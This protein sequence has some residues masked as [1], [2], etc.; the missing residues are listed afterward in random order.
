MLE[1]IKYLKQNKYNG[2]DDIEKL[3]KDFL[4]I[5]IKISYDSKITNNTRRIIF[6][7]S[8]S[9]RTH[10]FGKITYECN[11]LILQAPDWKVLCASTPTPKTNVKNSV[12]SD[13]LQK[14]IY[15]LYEITDGTVINLYYWNS[16]WKIS[17]ARGIDMTDVEL[18]TADNK[19]YKELLTDILTNMKYKTYQAFTDI[20]DN[21]KS[22]TFIIKHPILHKFRPELLLKFVHSYDKKIYKY[23]Y[24][25]DQFIHIKQKEIQQIPLK[26]IYKNL[27]SAFD[28]YVNNK[29]VLYGYILISNYK[30][31]TNHSYIVLESNLL[32]FIRQSLY[33]Q[34]FIQYGNYK[35][36]AVDVYA[37]L[38]STPYKNN[39]LNLFPE[40]K[41]LFDKFKNMHS[42][43][44]GTIKSILQSIKNATLKPEDL[45]SSSVKN[46]ES[47]KSSDELFD[48]IGL[49]FANEIK[50]L[51]NYA[52]YEESV[53]DI[54]INKII[55]NTSYTTIYIHFY[56]NLYLN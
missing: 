45:N 7:S 14:N 16:E 32:R 51:I 20:L 37:F 6:T 3:K 48:N 56:K 10:N 47:C 17:S 9:L 29:N 50:S 27:K 2:L 5:N 49:Y 36:I 18:P 28:D 22:Y 41:E 39:Y 30:N 42:L 19:T 31:A 13:G 40:K 4:E 33:D 52:N 21:N 46:L 43:L 24:D 12:V 38:S 55:L 15:K 54:H 11:G 26:N 44:V 1:T 23:I 25:E 35:N 53:L 8:K 34:K